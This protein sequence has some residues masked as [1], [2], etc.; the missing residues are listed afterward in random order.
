MSEFEVD[1]DNNELKAISE[2]AETSELKTLDANARK[3]KI[4][5]YTST[6]QDI[7]Q[8]MNIT[9]FEKLM[10]T[11]KKAEAEGESGF[12]LDKFRR[13]FGEILS[14]NLNYEAMTMLFMKIDANSDGTI[15]WDEF[16]T[17]MMMGQI[18]LGDRKQVFVEKD[19]KT[20]HCKSKDVIKRIDYIQKERKY[21]TVSRDAIATLWNPEFVLQKS[22]NLKDLIRT[23]SWVTDACFLHEYNKL[24][25][26]ND[27]RLLCIFDILS[28]KPRCVLIAGPIENN[29]LSICFARSH[30][31]E[32]DM[33]LFGD[34]GGYMNILTFQRRF[35]IENAT[36]GDPILFNSSL[37]AQKKNKIGMNYTRV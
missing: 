3:N 26:I 29:P 12:E 37:M 24:A 17:Y 4:P 21:V 10:N 34:D 14:G 6:Y 1:S 15:D 2:N 20:L 22:I 11:F 5:S 8:A 13:V 28:I 33:I 19:K 7:Q 27:D 25:L 30:D 18:E 16:S 35:F 31:E 36:D 9:H 23:D 32:N